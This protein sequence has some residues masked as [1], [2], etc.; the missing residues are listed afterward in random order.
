M[1]PSVNP[2]CPLPSLGP[3]LPLQPE[4]TPACLPDRP[5][6][7]PLSALPLFWSFAVTFKFYANCYL[8]VLLYSKP[9]ILN[10]SAL[11]RRHF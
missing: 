7:E 5:P 9:L 4:P 8:T 3:W 10:I 11:S 2:L 6:L 1:V